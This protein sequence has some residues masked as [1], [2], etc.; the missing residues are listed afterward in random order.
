MKGKKRQ[1]KDLLRSGLEPAG[2]RSCGNSAPWLEEAYNPAL[3][4]AT[5]RSLFFACWACGASRQPDRYFGPWLIERAHIA[6]KPRRE[7]R[8]L[9][10]MLCTVCHKTSHGER[11]AGFLRP[12]LSDGMLAAIKQL[13][14]PVWYDLEFINR[15]SVRLIEPEPVDPFYGC[16]NGR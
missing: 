4:Y 9:V 13:R 14:D 11:I 15:H 5:M 2:S 12:R 16:C 1:P 6:N 8:R 3:E 7:D 10:V